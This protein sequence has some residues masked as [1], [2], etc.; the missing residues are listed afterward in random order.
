MKRVIVLLAVLTVAISFAATSAVASVPTKKCSSSSHSDMGGMDM[1]GSSKRC[2]TDM[3]RPVVA[4]AREIAVTGDDFAFAPDS[5]T[6]KAGEDVTI[7]LTAQDIA[8]DIF[9]KGIGHVVHAKAGKTARG[10]LK[11]KKAGT[12]T[13]WCTVSGHKKAGMTGTITVTS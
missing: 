9:V 5:I 11:F 8:H 1:S 3:N 13:F 12:Y 7:V 6:V 4:G 2:T 10:G